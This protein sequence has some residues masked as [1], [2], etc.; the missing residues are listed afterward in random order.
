MDQGGDIHR[1]YLLRLDQRAHFVPFTNGHG[2][3][4]NPKECSRMKRALDKDSTGDK[5]MPYWIRLGSVFL[6]ISLTFIVISF[7]IKI[8]FVGTT[9]IGI[10]FPFHHSD[11]IP[12][13]Q[14]G[15]GAVIDSEHQRYLPLGVLLDLAS[16][17]FISV[18]AL[19]LFDSS[20]RRK[21]KSRLVSR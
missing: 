16:Y 6:G 17:F 21:I 2:S 19:R 9:E 5:R 3:T 1:P 7:L 12:W 8:G 15:A 14:R 20:R 18:L 13:G 11:S 10:P 4:F